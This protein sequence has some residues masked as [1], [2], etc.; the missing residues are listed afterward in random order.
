MKLL[1]CGKKHDNDKIKRETEKLSHLFF[2]SV[3]ICHMSTLRQALYQKLRA[4][5]VSK[6]TNSWST[7]TE[8][9][10]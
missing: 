6:R 3:N 7:Y 9:R 8:I 2:N 10:F 4:K 1:Y 5:D